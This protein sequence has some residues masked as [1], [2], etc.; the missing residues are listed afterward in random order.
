MTEADVLDMMDDEAKYATAEAEA[1]ERPVTERLTGLV[2]DG[3][4]IVD[5]GG[6]VISRAGEPTGEST[7]AEAL[8]AWERA[9]EQEQDA[10]GLVERWQAEALDALVRS[11]RMESMRVKAQLVAMLLSTDDR[12][13]AVAAFREKRAPVF[14]ES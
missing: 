3:R 13:E 14:N 5:A 8:D 9:R 11:V 6:E 10:A 4:N 7:L 12:R 2:Q 1:D